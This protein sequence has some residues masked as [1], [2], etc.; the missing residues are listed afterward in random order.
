VSD[1]Q[2]CTA[3]VSWN[4]DRHKNPFFCV[5]S[6]SSWQITC[7]HYTFRSTY[8]FQLTTNDEFAT[9]ASI[10]KNPPTLAA[11]MLS[12]RQRKALLATHALLHTSVIH[13]LTVFIVFEKLS[14][15]CIDGC[16]SWFFDFGL[17]LQFLLNNIGLHPFEELSEQG[18]VNEGIFTNHLLLLMR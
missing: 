13:P 11:M 4:K 17:T 15:I 6:L 16:T 5:C 8:S 18:K 9:T 3:N 12:I 7:L 1:T 10:T 2:Q 14:S